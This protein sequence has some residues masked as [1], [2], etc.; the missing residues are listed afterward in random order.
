MRIELNSG[1]LSGGSSVAVM[2]EN[3]R[4][5][6][7]SSEWLLAAFN[8]LKQYTCNI[9]GGVGV[10][11]D[12]LSGIEARISN[13]EI[14]S[15]NL[16]QTETQV[17]AFIQ[18]VHTT[19]RNI[20][21]IVVQNQDEF[22]EVNPWAKPAPQI[23]NEAW[24]DDAVDWVKQTGGNI[25]DGIDKIRGMIQEFYNYAK[26]KFEEFREKFEYWWNDRT[27]ITPIHIE[28][29][30]FD[31]ETYDAYGG[32]Q[33]G[34]K[35]DIER[36]DETAIRLYT[37]IIRENTGRTLS[38]EE[39]LRY[40]DAVRDEDGN[41]VV[42]GLNSE[43][44]EYAAIVNTIFEYY[45]H[46]ENGAEEFQRKFGFPLRDHQNRLN[47]NAILVDVYSKYD[48]PNYTGLTDDRAERSLER[49]MAEPGKD[50]HSSVQV[51]MKINATVTTTNIDNYIRDG[52]QVIVSAHNF[53]LY[54]EDGRTIKRPGKGHSMVVTGITEDGRYIVSTWGGKAYI[55]PKDCGK[56]IYI[57]E[58]NQK[59]GG[60]VT[61]DFNVIEYK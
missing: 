11:Q 59:I 6:A 22:Y 38:R 14:R 41:T 60:K 52:K 4:G 36:G 51:D 28:D 26:G 33:H 21:G 57:E 13:D 46:R 15:E 45:T 2:Q 18:Q 9:N 40:L 7:K 12:A 42:P 16:K 5:L 30:V 29:L 27:K 39:L 25:K 23:S 47:Y 53:I 19:D 48:D 3:L 34:P 35:E 24:I 20:A 56:E 1:G 8:N 32:R 61:L 31:Q 43:G 50:G 37:D 49:Y 58:D 10:L 44:C 17:N 55:D 54:T